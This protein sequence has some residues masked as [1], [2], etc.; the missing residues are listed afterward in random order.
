[1]YIKKITFK[2]FKDYLKNPTDFFWKAT[3]SYLTILQNIA[4]SSEPL[5]QKE[6]TT[7]RFFM[8][9]YSLHITRNAIW[10]AKSFLPTVL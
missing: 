2:A 6:N 1:M 7:L 5:Q 8:A 4:A 9:E 10:E 3:F